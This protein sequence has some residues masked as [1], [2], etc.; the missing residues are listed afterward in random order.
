MDPRKLF[1]EERFTGLCV[2]CGAEPETRDQCH[3]KSCS[4]SPFRTTCP[5]SRRAK[6][7]TTAFHRMNG[8]WHV[9]SS[10]DHRSARPESALRDKIRRILREDPAL[11][12]RLT[13]S[14]R[15]DED[16]NVSWRPE[17][18]R[19]RNVVLKLA[20]GHAAYEFS[21]PR[22]GEPECIW[23]VSITAMSRQQ[24]LSFQGLAHGVW[25]EIGSRAF[26]RAVAAWPECFRKAAL[27]RFF[28]KG[29][30]VTPRCTPIKSTFASY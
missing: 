29:D 13:A 16:G 27:G 3:R 15:E 11:A 26:I 28:R 5:L 24:F 4:T 20:R 18:E 8:T 1:A 25:P 22:L 2:Y 17:V 23:V 19:V 30:T 21:E 6:D 9:L 7:A 10:A 14:R 12:A